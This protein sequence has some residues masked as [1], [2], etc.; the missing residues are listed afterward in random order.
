MELEPDLTMTSDL[1]MMTSSEDDDFAPPEGQ[2]HSFNVTTFDCYDNGTL[3]DPVRIEGM[4]MSLSTAE[5]VR[6]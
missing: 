2:F 4:N 1:T 6:N 3:I 5:Q